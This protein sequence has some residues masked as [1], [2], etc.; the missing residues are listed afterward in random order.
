ML[1]HLL[2]DELSLTLLEP[3]HAEPLFQVVD[4]NRAYLR[5]RL[6]WLDLTTSAD[7][8]RAFIRRTQEQFGRNDGFQTLITYRGEIAG[9][10]GHHRIDWDNRCTWLGYWLAE[11]FQGRGL[12]TTACRA[13]VEHSFGALDLHRI[14]IHVDPG[15]ARSRAVAERL[16]FTREGLIRDAEWLYDRFVDHAVYGLLQPEWRAAGTGRNPG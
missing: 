14:E 2:S 3:H 10:V 6:P 13:Y 15:N 5:E 11:P 12:M 9:V 8:V 7:D 1:P 4:Q 16:G